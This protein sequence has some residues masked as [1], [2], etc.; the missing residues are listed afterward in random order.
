MGTC[1]KCAVFVRRV[2]ETIVGLIYR[3]D[4]SARTRDLIPARGQGDGW[5]IHVSSV[6]VAAAPWLGPPKGG[7]GD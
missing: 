4:G 5:E 2:E 6:A 7:V 3:G 1:S